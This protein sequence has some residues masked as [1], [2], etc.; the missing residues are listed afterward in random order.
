MTPRKI[1]SGGQTGADRAALDWA[2]E[3]GVPH[4]GWCPKGRK[5]E[6]GAIDQ[7]YNLVETPSEDY[8]Q[9]TEWNVR[10]SDGTAVFSIRSELR[11]GSLLTINMAEQYNKPVIHLCKEDEQ[12]NH[13][14]ELRS[15][16]VEF[17][18]SVL[19]VAGPRESDESGVYRFVARVLDQAFGPV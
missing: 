6:D 17:E 1:I 11:G 8:S 13:A 14:Q 16:I 9:R 15:F 5:A 3:R 4:G 12:A 7:R 19:N 2:I 18:I 10:D